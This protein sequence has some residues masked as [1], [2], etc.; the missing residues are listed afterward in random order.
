MCLCC[1]RD[2]RKIQGSI[3][4]HPVL[5]VCRRKVNAHTFIGKS[6][7]LEHSEKCFSS[8]TLQ[9]W[10]ASCSDGGIKCAR[11]KTFFPS[12]CFASFPFY[13]ATFFLLII[14]IYLKIKSRI[15][16]KEKPIGRMIMGRLKKHWTYAWI[17]IMWVNKIWV[18]SLFFIKMALSSPYS[19]KKEKKVFFYSAGCLYCDFWRK[20]KKKI[21]LTKV[22][23]V[24]RCCFRVER[25]F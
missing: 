5:G 12:M 23:K 13:S 20:N 25:K 2:G 24:K 3:F 15:C 9:L 7:T 22:F 17:E 18:L 6:F 19:L 14:R 11:E 4:F 10:K 16:I 8:L 1:N 21:L